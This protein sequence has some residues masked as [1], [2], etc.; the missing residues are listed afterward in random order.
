MLSKLKVGTKIGG[1]FGIVLVLTVVVAVAAL[2]SIGSM[3]ANMV[4]IESLG[5]RQ[6][7]SA[8]L[9]ASMT[10]HVATARGYILYGED[11]L[12]N[13]YQK[14]VSIFKETLSKLS[15]ELTT[16]KGKKLLQQAADGE[17][18]YARLFDQEI[19]PAYKAGNKARIQELALGPMAKAGRSTIDA[20]NGI[21][22]LADKM[23]ADANEAGNTAASRATTIVTVFAIVAALFGIFIAFTIT[24]SIVKP[25]TSLVGDAER[26]AQGDLTVNVQSAGQDEIGRLSDS[27][28]QMVQNLRDTVLQVADSSSKV[29]ASSQTLSA[30]AE[31]VSRATQQITETIQQ[32][33]AGSQEQSR[34]A[35][36]TSQSMEQLGRAVQEVATGSQAQARTV[37][38][39][40]ALIQ[41]ITAAIEQVAKLSQEA[42]QNG[43]QVTE[44]ANTGGKQVAAAVG[45]MDRIKA[46]TDKVAGMVE[47][48]GQSSQQIGAIVE[49][50]DD[51]AEQTNLLAL[52]AAIEAAR[53]GEHGKGFA[54]V[55]DEVRKLAERSSKAT[56]EIAELIGSIQQMTGH[57]VDAMNQ[58]SQE[59]AEG[60]ELA[61]QA[62]GALRSIQEAVAGI[63][64]QIEDMSAA[65]AQM[66]GSSAEVIKAIESVSAVT[67]QTTAA[68]EEMSAASTEVTQQ[69]EQVAAVSEENAAASEEVSAST[70]EQSA[71]VEELTSS[72]EEL[73][74]MAQ[75][76]QEL[77]NQFKLDDDRRGGTLQDV[78]G[79][80]AARQHRRAA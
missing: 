59:V 68:A 4:E 14:E 7:A 69:V 13:D 25:V 11:S 26:V 31:E 32:V 17:A 24:R 54:V 21:V 70:E 76:L 64:R 67:Q 16:E 18:E 41:Q 35:Q 23:M 45:G 10:K 56:G 52:N 75:Q 3:R 65:A 12:I 47:Q 48:L 40:V 61:N 77:V 80:V 5:G 33:A 43:N 38:E 34:T 27:F 51:I 46:A 36:A 28:A 2:L 20:C 57:A 37:D 22:E 39:S 9:A 62:G 60:T 30:T 58:G 50:I 73:A 44:V 8:A 72:A 53:A 1:G 74:G 6:Q 78:S 71:A 15:D 79:R 66:S 29:T 63:V 42:A 19:I 55:A 49:T